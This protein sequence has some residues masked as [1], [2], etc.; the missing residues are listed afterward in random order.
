MFISGT[1]GHACY[2]Q[3]HTRP[4]MKDKKL[5]R[6]NFTKNIYELTLQQTTGG[7]ISGS[8]VSGASGTTFNLSATPNAHW[9][10]SSYSANGAD[11][12]GSSGTYTNSDVTAK[13]TFW[14]DPKY[15]LTIQQQTGGTVASN[16][17]S[18]YQNDT[19]TLTPTPANK[20]TLSA[21]QTTG[22]TM[23][24]NNGKF[25]T[26]N[27]TVKPVWE[28]HPTVNVGLTLP[29][30]AN[31]GKDCQRLSIFGAGYYKNGNYSYKVQF[32]DT[33]K[34]CLQES[35]ILQDV[36]YV[37]ESISEY[38][39]TRVARFEIYPVLT[40]YYYEGT[41]DWQV[42]QHVDAVY[43]GAL[44]QHFGKNFTT[45]TPDTS[46]GFTAAMNCPNSMYLGPS[47]Y[48]SGFRGVFSASVLYYADHKYRVRQGSYVS[49]WYSRASGVQGMT[50]YFEIPCVSSNDPIIFEYKAPDYAPISGK[51]GFNFK[52]YPSTASLTANTYYP[53]WSGK[54]CY[55]S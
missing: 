10:F 21:Y 28:Y 1:S 49:D 54:L 30:T 5:L 43:T 33:N 18:G 36:P 22:T 31:Y 29:M 24:G 12:T 11:L 47:A 4:Y 2:N 38:D 42:D 35:Q 20:Y 9:N 46:R 23:T 27:V 39:G 48:I 52:A 55:L 41:P 6:L 34:T 50:G 37:P 13:A 44:K 14:E 32:K 15:T 25:N 40:K 19:F 7:T 51:V 45:A 3:Q 17:S 16:K 8:P 53:S 26:S